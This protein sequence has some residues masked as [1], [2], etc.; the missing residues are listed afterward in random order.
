MAI[1]SALLKQIVEHGDFDTWN[2]L[3]Q[4]YLPQGEYQKLWKVVDKHVHKYHELPSFEDLKSEI[5]SRELQE[6]IYAIETVDTDV[7][8]YKLLEY[9]KDQFTQAEILEK[10][11]EYIDEHI[12]NYQHSQKRSI[13]KF[14]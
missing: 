7:P 11:E 5:R 10:I 12:T 4:H 6:K 2:D 3:K 13:R 9:L 1:E 14:R 8:A